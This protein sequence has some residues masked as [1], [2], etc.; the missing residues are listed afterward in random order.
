[1]T[2]PV[3]NSLQIRRLAACAAPGSLRDICKRLEPNHSK[4]SLRVTLSRLVEMNLVAIYRK[5]AAAEP[6]IYEISALGDELLRG[7]GR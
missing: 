4:D 3:L 2:R 5:N 6:Y 7:L 1:M